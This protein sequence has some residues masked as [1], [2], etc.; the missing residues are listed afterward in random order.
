MRE[1]TFFSNSLNSSSF[2]FRYS[3]I[4][5]CASF[6]ASLTRFERSGVPR[7]DERRIQEGW[8]GCGRTFSSCEWVSIF[9]RKK[10][11]HRIKDSRPC[12]TIF[13]A[14]LSAFTRDLVLQILGGRWRSLRRGGFGCPW[15]F[16][17]T[18]VQSK[19]LFIGCR[20]IETL[21]SLRLSAYGCVDSKGKLVIDVVESELRD[22]CL[23]QANTVL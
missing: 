19:L 4:S 1:S 22:P 6:L 9:T 11:I 3:S 23:R 16:A 13:W 20:V 15:S 2:C 18:A 12:W 17:Q 5:F 10:G 14:S 7:L 21:P 8:G